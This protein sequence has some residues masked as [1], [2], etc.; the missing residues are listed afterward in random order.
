MCDYQD[1]VDF[2]EVHGLPE[3]DDL[4]IECKEI[5]ELADMINAIKESVEPQTFTST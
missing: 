5:R 4:Y 2:W 1:T 3:K